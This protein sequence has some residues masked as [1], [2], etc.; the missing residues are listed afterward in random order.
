MHCLLIHKTIGI[1]RKKFCSCQWGAEWSYS[2]HRPGSEDPHR[3]ERKFRFASLSL[4]VGS[5]EV[6]VGGTSVTLTDFAI[7]FHLDVP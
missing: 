7:N 3:R 1:Q 5:P 6:T 4:F 2:V